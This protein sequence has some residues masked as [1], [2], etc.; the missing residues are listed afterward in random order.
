MTAV[1]ATSKTQQIPKKK[2]F[3][4]V[5]QR[6]ISLASKFPSVVKKNPSLKSE[7]QSSPKLSLMTQTISNLDFT[8]A[9]TFSMFEL[10]RVYKDHNTMLMR[11]A[12]GFK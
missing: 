4:I 11:R 7:V 5:I 3:G 8:P 2:N 10:P 1:E 6:K 12:S 9:F